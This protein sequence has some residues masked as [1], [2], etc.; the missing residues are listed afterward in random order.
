MKVLLLENIDSVARQ[1]FQKAGHEVVEIRRALPP[2]ELAEIA[3][4]V[5]G[6]RSQTRITEEVFQKPRLVVAA[7]C[8]G[9]NQIDLAACDRNGC[10]TFH[11]RYNNS[12]SVAELCIGSL[13]NLG[14]WD[15][16]ANGSR[17]MR[18]KMLGIVGYGNVGQQVGHLA[19]A[20][21]MRL[22]F[23]DI[24]E[25]AAHGNATRFGSMA[26]LLAAADAVT[27]HVDGRGKN[28]N[29]FGAEQIKAMKPGAFVLNFSR[30]FVPVES[31]IAEALKS[32]HLG[33]VALDVHQ[34]E[35][36]GGQNFQ[37]PLRGLPNVLLTPHI[38]GS[39]EEAQR[40]I[41][42]STTKRVLDYLHYGTVQLSPSFP[43]RSYTESPIAGTRRI[44][45]LHQNVPG[46]I[47]AA[48]QVLANHG[49]NIVGQ[50]LM[51]NDRVGYAAFDAPLPEPEAVAEELSRLQGSI[52]VRIL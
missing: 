27:F 19:E 45:Y 13:I 23:Y 4:D 26:E 17:E 10:V 52:R 5:I 22:G 9:I 14:V 18:G 7:Y 31:D 1:I 32:G 49:V 41:G 12:R 44:I 2:G 33:G 3:A 15:K 42:E 6:I 50:H 47:G 16:T 35:P 51:T 30:G 40:A 48:A 11:D 36:S 38:G 29:L 34:N 21:G 20:M 39:T 25:R 8:I 28:K 24:E 43:G 37:S 46:Q